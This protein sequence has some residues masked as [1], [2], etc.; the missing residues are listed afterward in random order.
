MC[1]PTTTVTLYA[2]SLFF[3]KFYFSLSLSLSR[4][5]YHHILRDLIFSIS[6][7]LIVT[8]SFFNCLRDNMIP[9]PT[10]INPSPADFVLVAI[11]YL[12]K[13][14]SKAR[15][16]PSSTPPSVLQLLLP[17]DAL[18]RTAVCIQTR[19]RRKSK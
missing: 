1:Q 2:L 14:H 16:S 8:S 12:R 19:G 9:Y 6:L 5:H 11:T 13:L 17:A 3:F 15:R 4:Y 7:K 18:T 10:I